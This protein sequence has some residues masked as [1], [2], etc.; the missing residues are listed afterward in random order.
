MLSRTFA[1]VA[2]QMSPSV[3]RISITKGGGNSKHNAVHRG[4]NPFE[5]TPFERFFGDEDGGSADRSRSRR[6]SARAWSSTRR[7]TSSPTTTSS[8]TPID[9]KVTLRRRHDRHGQGRRHAIRTTDIAVV[10]VDGVGVTPA[11]IGDSDAAAGRRVGH[12]DRQPVRPRPHGHRR[13]AVSAKGRAR[14]RA[15]TSSRTSCRPTRRSTPATRAVRWCNLDGEVIGINTMIAGM[16]HRHRLRGAV[17]DGQAVAEQLIQTGKV[18]RPYIGIRMQEVTPEVAKGARQERAGRRARWSRRSS[19]A[20][21]RKRPAPSRATS[22]STSTA[23]RRRLRPTCSAR[24]SSRAR[25]DR[26]ST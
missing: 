18:R 23:R 15:A 16:R 7:A 25:S 26:R 22:S 2:S 13:R 8:R 4:G 20:R 12:R 24:S 1:Q 14:L 9:V 11:K 6:A 10:K 17:V 19:R 3:V 21:R 5:G